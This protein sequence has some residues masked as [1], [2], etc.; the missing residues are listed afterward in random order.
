MWFLDRAPDCTLRLDRRVTANLPRIEDRIIGG[1]NFL[2]RRRLK[3][4]VV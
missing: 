4:K 2:R 3:R 1:D